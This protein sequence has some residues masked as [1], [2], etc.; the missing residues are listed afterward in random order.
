MREEIRVMEGWTRE[1]DDGGET[2]WNQEPL[3]GSGIQTKEKGCQDRKGTNKER[4]VSNVW[5]L[6]PKLSVTSGGIAIVLENQVLTCEEELFRFRV[7]L[8]VA[9]D[10]CCLSVLSRCYLLS[11]EPEML[12]K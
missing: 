2:V 6:L 4:G 11:S 10:L 9:Y 1:Y 5:S 3:S 12:Y 8:N 7:I